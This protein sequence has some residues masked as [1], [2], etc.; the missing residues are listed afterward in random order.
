MRRRKRYNW[1]RGGDGGG[2]GL[3]KG[4]AQG[5]AGGQGEGGDWPQHAGSLNTKPAIKGDTQPRCKQVSLA[6]M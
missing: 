3:V 1:W 6:V 2:G 4:L 5:Q